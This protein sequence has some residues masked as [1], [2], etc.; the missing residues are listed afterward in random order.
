MFVEY[1]NGSFVAF[2]YRNGNIVGKETNKD[3]GLGEY[4]RE[5]YQL[6]K[7]KNNY[8]EENA[9]YLE[10][11]ELVNKLNAHPIETVV[12]DSS[13]Y[14]GI[15]AK[16]STYTIAYNPATN[17]YS[18]YQMPTSESGSDLKVSDSFNETVDSMIDRDEKL[19]KFYREG[20]S[21]KVTFVSALLIVIS[22]VIFIV[23]AI[24]ILAKYLEKTQKK[25]KEGK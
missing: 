3:I 21:T 19:I 8:T 20:E 16:N 25:L 7:E 11:K 9:S 24:I 23:F 13:Y 10:A 1:K 18:V 5:Y 4:I 14:G 22:I 17:D 2:N 12:G 6:S 15:P